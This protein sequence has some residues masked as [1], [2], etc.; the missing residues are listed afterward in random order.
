MPLAAAAVAAAQRK[1]VRAGIIPAQRRS[2]DPLVHVE[3]LPSTFEPS[4]VLWLRGTLKPPLRLKFKY[5][6]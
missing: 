4:D 3:E 5:V 2:R 6:C 1:A